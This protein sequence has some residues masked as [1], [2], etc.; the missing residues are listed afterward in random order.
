LVHRA[1][2]ARSR[3]P[4]GFPSLKSGGGGWA[5]FILHLT[6]YEAEKRIRATVNRDK[7]VSN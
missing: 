7:A 1:S 2:A 6:Q 4:S 5:V 3:N